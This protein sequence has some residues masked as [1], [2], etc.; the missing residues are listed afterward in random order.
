MRF[1]LASAKPGTFLLSK[2]LSG[3]E[4][5]E[6]SLI[7]FPYQ[8]WYKTEKDGEAE[9]HLL[10]EKTG[11]DHNVKIDGTETPLPFKSS[12][13]PAGAEEA[14]QNVFM[15][16]PG[17]KA[18]VTLPE[19][20]TT[21]YVKECGVD[22]GVYDAVKVNGSKADKTVPGNSAGSA[23][24]Y[25]YSSKKESISDRQSVEFDNHVKEGVMRTLSL[26]KKLYD[27]NGRDLLHYPDDKTEF[28]FRLYL[29]NENDNADDLP[30]A[31]M[32]PY[33][34]KDADGYYC[35]WDTGSHGFVSIGK[36]EYS[37]LKRQHS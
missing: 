31:N 8:I 25:D 13:T 33:H 1:N 18:V 36:N 24:R 28:S 21:Y 15:L 35:R 9:Y 2:K 37:Q 23:A 10:G 29:G 17:Q 6:N 34:V 5:T 20:A 4:E 12:F 16:K 11:N 26:T 7:E 27:V 19:G 3:T 22:S 14:Y 30:S 32:H